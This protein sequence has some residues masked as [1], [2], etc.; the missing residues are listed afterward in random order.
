MLRTFNETKP[1]HAD[2][3]DFL[4]LRKIHGKEQQRARDLFLYALLG[5]WPI[6]APRNREERLG[7]LLPPNETLTLTVAK[8]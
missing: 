4:E 6:H 8:V 1:W 3:C 5:A 7:A 2:A